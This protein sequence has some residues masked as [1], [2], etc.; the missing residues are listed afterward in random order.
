M[1]KHPIV[2]QSASPSESAIRRV[3]ASIPRGRVAT[4]GEVADHAGYPLHHRQ[5]AQILRKCGD[6]LPWHR[7]VGSGGLIK[8]V[9][10]SA[11]EQRLRLQME[12]VTFRGA[13]VDMR[14][15]GLFVNERS[16]SAR[17]RT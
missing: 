11:L 9:L 13:R 14:A 12:G 6:T 10:E 2:R 15:H 17:R 1:R 3:I 5:V 16:S 8:T 4:Y 7:V